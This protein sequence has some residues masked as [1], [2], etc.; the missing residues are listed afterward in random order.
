[1]WSAKKHSWPHGI[2]WKVLLLTSHQLKSMAYPMWSADKHCWPHG[3][4]WRA[5]LLPSDPL[6]NIT[7]HMWSV[8]SMADHIGSAEEHY[9]YHLISCIVLLT[10]CD[11]LT[12]MADHMGSAE[13]HYCYHL[14][15]CIV[16]LTTCDQLTSRLTTWDQLKSITTNIWSSA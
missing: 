11:Q 8:T 6:H 7:D 9:C 5:V 16:L 13:E 12:S 10:T 1:M 2:S 14:I 4:S 3:I 15:S